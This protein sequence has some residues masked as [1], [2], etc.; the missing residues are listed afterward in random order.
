MKTLL[1][2]SGFA[3][4]YILGMCALA[5]ATPTP[6]PTPTPIP[7]EGRSI[8]GSYSAGDVPGSYMYWTAQ[9][10][11]G[12]DKSFIRIRQQLDGQVKRGQA[13]R[14]LVQRYRTAA[15]LKPIDAQAQFRWAYAAVLAYE[16]R[17]KTGRDERGILTGVR[18]AMEKPP[19][20]KS[21]QYTRVRTLICSYDDRWRRD[22]YIEKCAL[23]LV[24]RSPSDYLVKYNFAFGLS[25][26]SK[27]LKTQEVAYQWAKQVFARSPNHAKAHYLM[28]FVIESRFDRFK[29]RRMAEKARQHIQKAQKILP[30]NHFY[31]K[32]LKIQ[33]RRI[34]Q[35]IR[36]FQRAGKLKL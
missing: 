19:S 26:T 31:Q 32:H 28:G 22:K 6:A 4:S 21:Y 20:P 8:F 10:W 7:V 14:T 25:F 5:W 29:E 17:W 30:V 1:F 18:E 2:K 15:L 16:N 33:I 3:L 23:R 13:V 24:K 35:G 12:S 9:P 36:I 27:P 34:D 11:T